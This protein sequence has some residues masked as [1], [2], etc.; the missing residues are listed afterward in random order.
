[1]TLFARLVTSLIV[2]GA[3]LAAGVHAEAASLSLSWNA[4][5]MNA[6]GS[7]LQDLAGY[8]VYVGTSVPTCPG[9]SFHSVSSPTRSPGSG[10]TVSTSVTQLSAGTRYFV[11]IT[12]VDD[13]G[14]ESGCTGAAN[15]VAQADLEVAPSGT[16]SFGGIAVNAT[17]ERTFT[18]QNARDVS[19]SG[20]VSTSAPFSVV[21][22]ASFTLAPGAS[23]TVT[24]RFRPTAVG[25]FAGN[26]NFTAG[27]DTVSRG[28]SGSTTGSAGSPPSSPPPPP[29][30]PSQVLSVAKSGSGTGTVTSSPAGI[31]CG[32]TCTRTYAA[33]T[34]ITLTASAASGSTF[35]GWGGACN[36]TG[37]CTVTMSAA[38]TVTATFNQAPRP[39]TSA[40]PPPGG[41]TATRTKTDSTGATFTV[42]WSAASGATS[43]RWGAAFSDGSA[44]RDGTVSAR[45]I[46]LKM[47]Y[48]SSGRAFGA[49]VCIRSIG[50]GGAQRGDYSCA[51]L[52]VPARPAAAAPSAPPPPPPPDYGWGVG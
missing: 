29:S 52:S 8:R 3:V 24:V 49:M 45:S 22:G 2:L 31:S 39:P 36:G 48:H 40:P 41:V 21:S 9:G 18:V 4:P 26:V 20:A 10:Q 16:T 19:I 33:G 46:Q 37:S 42:S 32:A 25:N 15:A 38:R 44:P 5:T 23:R 6:D 51:A 47:P 14:N 50:A 30:T 43:Y 28:V 1:L 17:A 34:Q 12:A 7:P 35:A 11:R 27:G 13:N